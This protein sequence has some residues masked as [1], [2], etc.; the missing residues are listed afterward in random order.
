MDSKWNDV[1]KHLSADKLKKYQFGA[2]KQKN[3]FPFLP[4]AYK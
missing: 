2:K 4:L 3:V 1:D